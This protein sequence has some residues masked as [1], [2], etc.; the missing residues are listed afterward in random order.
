M[1]GNLIRQPAVANQFYDGDPARLGYELG[2]LIG[3]VKGAQPALA[4]ISPHAGYIYSGRVAG[5]AYSKVVV[6]KTAVVLGPNHTGLGAAAAIM[7][8]GTW[9][10]PLGNVPVNKELAATIL[11]NSRFLMNDVQAHLHEHSLEVQIPFLQYRQPQLQIVPICLSHISYEA[12]EDIGVSIA[13][14]IQSHGEDVLIVASTDMTHYEPQEQAEAKDRLAIERI[15]G[16]DPKG[17]Y[18]TV[19]SYGISMCGIMPTTVAL[20]AAL[21]LGATEADLV[22]YAT[23]GDVTGDYASVVGYASFVIK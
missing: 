16:L 1:N 9:A 5:K 3:P 15:L 8:E 19:L 13:N 21:A 18:K 4:I 7:T 22:A 10:M 23:S 6:P 2:K 11:N 17:L 12:C 14:G 20:I